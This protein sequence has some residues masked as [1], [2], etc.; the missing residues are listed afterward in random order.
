MSCLLPLFFFLLLRPR[1]GFNLADGI[2]SLAAH[3]VEVYQAHDGSDHESD[4]SSDADGFSSFLGIAFN[5][6]PDYPQRGEGQ[7]EVQPFQPQAVHAYQGLADVYQVAGR[8]F[9]GVYSF[10]AVYLIN[11]GNDR[12]FGLEAEARV[13]IARWW[14]MTL[15]A[16]G[17]EYMFKTTYEGGRDDSVMSYTLGM[18]NSF[19]AGRT[20]RI[21]FDA[22]AL[23]PAVLSQG[24][25]KGYFYFDLAIRQQILGERL[26]ASLVFHDA[27]HTAR[28]SNRR[29]TEG[30]LSVTSVRPVYPNI[31]LSLAY[32]FNVKDRKEHSGA[33]STGTIFEGKD[34]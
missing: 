14:D 31:V 23:G 13:K 5:E 6:K 16:S 24:R 22:N 34:F 3:F 18:I 9:F 30:L 26:S 15:T 32:S 33:I 2:F 7:A 12:S 20:T 8:Y 4:A 27:F 19:K 11:A 10:V 25:E 21:Q 1:I 29:E 28:Y 17:Y